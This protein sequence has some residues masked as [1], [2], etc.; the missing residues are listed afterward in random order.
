MPAAVFAPKTAAARARALV[1]APVL[2]QWDEGAFFAPVV[3]ALTGAGVHV[4]VVDTLAAWDED[5]TSLAALTD[6]WRTLLPRF[7]PFDLLCGNALG[8]ALAQALLPA[9]DP[10]TGVLLVSAPAVADALL[11]SRLTEIA[12]AAGA[13]R[14]AESLALLH[15]YVLPEGTPEQAPADA[16][17]ADPG[18]AARRLAGGLPLLCGIDSTDAVTGHPG[19]LLNVVGGRSRLVGARHT[20]AAPHHH[21]QVMPGCGMR[22]HTESAPEVSAAVAD[23]T[24]AFLREREL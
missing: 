3:R 16:V 18:G 2:P 23:F 9:V 14:L 15:H 8:G 7:G 11:E 20:A 4:T 19:P 6:R 22:P 12:D 13:G 17:L 1:L 10:A 21:V 5:V 24:G